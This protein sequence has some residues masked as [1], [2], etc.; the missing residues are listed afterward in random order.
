MKIEYFKEYS[1]YL[2]RDMEM[3]VF[4]HSGAAC[5]VIPAQ[6]GR[7]YD[8][9]NFK[10]VEACQSLIDEG[11]IQFYC[12]DTID[13]ESWSNTS[14]PNRERI[15][16]HEAW[17]NYVTKEI[18]PQIK[19]HNYSSN[20]QQYRGT[21]I[22]GCSMGATHT[23]NIFFR[24]PDLFDGMIALSG[25]YNTKFAFQDYSDDL[26]Y[27]NSVFRYLNEMPWDHPYLEQYRQKKIV[28][29]VGQGAWEEPMIEDTHQM[30]NL[31]NYKKIPAWFD[32]WG[33]DV[34]HDWP[35]WRVQLPYYLK[36]IL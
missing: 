4:G 30:E 14:R 31:L 6:D 33:Y 11:R 28:F 16:A 13:K 22:T 26:I 5:L 3:K 2:N 35:W 32:Y 15:E 20:N 17:F 29:C 34:D 10:M 12:I 9:E 8:F 19:H 25:L 7:F 1:Y 21:F 27:N 24:R 36:H 18:M 23:C